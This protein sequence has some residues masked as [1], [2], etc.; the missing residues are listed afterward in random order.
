VAR[1]RTVFVCQ[2]CAAQFAKW[3]GRCSECGAWETVVEE[4]VVPRTSGGATGGGFGGARTSVAINAARAAQP[5]PLSS[6]TSESH[7]RIGTGLEELDRVLGGGIVPGSVI[8]LGGDPGIG[9][10]TIGLQVLAELARD[11]LTALYVSGEESPEQVKLRADRLQCNESVLILPETCVE[12]ILGH[13]AAVKPGILLIDSIQTMHSREL[14]SA[15]GSVG[16]V[17]ECAAALVAQAKAS[18]RPTILVGHVTKE[19]TIAGP[20]VL[21]HVVD[22]V[23]YF[24]G[25]Q[26]GGLRLLRAVKNRF[27]ATNEVGVFEMGE[28]GLV[29]ISNPS[30]VLLAERPRG[31]SGSAVLPAIEGTRP[32]LVEVQALSARSSLAMPRRTTLGLDSNRVAVLTAIVDKRAGLKLYEHDLFVSVAGGIRV[33]EPAADLAI[34]AA[35]GSSASDA[36][37]PEELILFGEVGLAGEVRAVRH[38]ETRLR[39]AHKLGFTRAIVPAATAKQVRAPAGL[40]VQG[41][42]SVL[43]LWQAL[44][45]GRKRAA[46]AGAG[47][48]DH[49]L[50]EI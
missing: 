2:Q 20:R 29:D 27:G 16:Q 37:L 14:T 41:V 5:M 44:F 9:K 18:G 43:E 8:L 21:E 25:D 12:E 26:G 10:S 22:T 49:A 48:S 3:L 30:A 13:V 42:A 1:A 7:A 6:V 46:A 39:E 4:M 23:L 17:R 50:D 32:L 45:G 19:G 31:A 15:A 40:E 24:E 34:I 47:R 33:Q 11:G 35:I 36:P 38:P 28:R